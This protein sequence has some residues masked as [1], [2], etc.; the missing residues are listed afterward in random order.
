MIETYNSDDTDII[1]YTYNNYCKH[2]L[3]YESL[4]CSMYIG[5]TGYINFL[6]LKLRLEKWKRKLVRIIPMYVR[7]YSGCYL[8]FMN[9]TKNRGEIGSSAERFG[10]W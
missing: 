6:T 7:T 10:Y 9:E 4:I 5:K 8:S 3:R 2:P 1:Q